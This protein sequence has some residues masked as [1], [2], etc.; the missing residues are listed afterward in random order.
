[1]KIKHLTRQGNS[2]SV[3]IDRAILDLADI[4]EGTPLK[5]TLEGRKITLE[6]ITEAEI[7]LRFTKAAEEVEQQF[8]RAFKRLAE[9]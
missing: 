1:M 2:L 4:N 9:K 5:M 8:G 6:P 3:I 7:E